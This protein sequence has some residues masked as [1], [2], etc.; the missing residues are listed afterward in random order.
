MK[1]RLQKLVL[2]AGLVLGATASLRAQVITTYSN[3]S[4]FNGAVGTVG[5]T[6]EDFT[7]TFHFPITTGVLS[8]T[9]NLVVGSG[10]AITP[11]MIQPGVTYSTAIGTGN[12]FNID[13][14]ASFT[15]G[16]LDSVTGVGALTVTFAGPIAAFGFDT[17]TFMGS[18][19]NMT[20][21]FT[22][23]PA[24]TNTFAITSGTP[25]FYGFQSGQKNITSFVLLGSNATTTFGI[26]NFRFQ[27]IPEPSTWAL[28][29]GGSVACALL[30]WRR[31][32]RA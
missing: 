3:L 2:L 15:G 24:Y 13:A 23:G 9:T 29:G 26:D 7:N 16:F 17:T 20:I 19:F 6:V 21:N 18:S 25:T 5:M 27:S 22:S 30:R 31:Q 14:G 1:A 28:L 12:F 8:S 4:T 32:L 10:P 11:G